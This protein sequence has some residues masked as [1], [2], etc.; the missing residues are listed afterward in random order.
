MAKPAWALAL[1]LAVAAMAVLS[2]SASAQSGCAA[3]TAL[4]NQANAQGLTGDCDTLLSARDT[5]AGTGSLNWS[6]SLAIEEWNGVSV[7]GTSGRVTGLNLRAAGLDGQIPA[8]LGNLDHLQSLHLGEN[9]LNGGIPAELGRLDAL[10]ELYLN[11]NRL[12]GDIPPELD[13][14]GVLQRLYLNGNQLDGAIPPALGGLASLRVLSLSQNRLAGE[15]PVE[16]GLLGSLRELYLNGNQLSGEIPAE[17]G[18]L[19]SLERLYLYGNQFTGVIPTALGGLTNLRV[20]SLSHNQLTGEIPSELYGLTSLQS[21]YLDGNRLD[22]M[23]PDALGRLA[24][25]QQLRLGGNLLTG[26]VPHTLAGFIIDDPLLG[27]PICAA[28]GTSGS[29]TV[30]IA[31]DGPR[32][33]VR[34]NTPIG[35]TATF[36]QPVSNFTAD[37]IRVAFGTVDNFDGTGSSYTFDVTPNAAGAVTVE[38]PAGLATDANDDGNAATGPLPLGIPYDDNNDARISRGEVI[39]A[40]S[41]YFARRINRVQAIWM[42]GLYFTS[43]DPSGRNANAGPD[44]Q[45]LESSPVRLDGTAT[46]GPEGSISSYRWEQV[47]NGSRLVPLAGAD[48]A[49]PTFT[50]PGLSND[51]DF[52]LRLTVTYNNGETSEDEVIITGRP[53][54]GVIVGAVS[55]HTATINSEAVFDIRLRSRPSAEVVIPVSSSDESEGIPQQTDVVFTPENWHRG[56]PVV[57]RGQNPAVQGG[58]QD[59]EIILGDTESEDSYYDGLA[60]S[61]VAMRGIVLEIA[62][63]EEPEPLVANLPATIEPRVS[64]TGRERLSFALSEAPSGMSVDFSYGTISWTP[65]E[66]DEGQTFDVTVKVNDG[67]LFSETTFQVTV[68]QSEPITTEIQGNVLTVDDQ[69]TDL[70]GMSITALPADTSTPSTNPPTLQ[71]LQAALGKASGESV[72]EIPSWITPISDVFVVKSTFENPVQLGF[73]IS[74]L[75][76]DVSPGSIN[77]YAYSEDLDADGASWGQIGIDRSFG[78]TDE[79]PVYVLSLVALQGLAFFGYHDTTPQ[80]AIAPR[81]SNDAVRAPRAAEE[82]L[83]NRPRTTVSEEQSCDPE[84]VDPTEPGFIDTTIK[85]CG[86]SSDDVECLPTHSSW[87]CTYAPDDEVLIKVVNFGEDPFTDNPENI[88]WLGSGL[89]VKDLAISAITAQLGFEELGLAYDKVITVSISRLNGLGKVKWLE[90]RK[91]I[92]ITDDNDY[93]PDEIQGA[94]VHEYF[95]HVQAH[96][97]NFDFTDR[98]LIN[99][100]R[101]RSTVWLLESTALWYEDELGNTYDSFD[102]Y[103]GHGLNEKIME[104]GLNSRKGDDAANP[105]ARAGFIKLLNQACP[106]FTSHISDMFHANLLDFSGIAKLNSLLDD[107]MCDFGTHLGES[108]KGNLE[109]GIAFYNYATQLKNDMRLLDLNEPEDVVNFLPA[110]FTGFDPSLKNVECTY[111]TTN[112]AHLN[113]DYNWL[114]GQNGVFEL[115]LNDIPTAG[116]YSFKIPSISLDDEGIKQAPG[117]GIVLPRLPEGMIA[118][119][120]IEADREII[121][122]IPDIMG[123]SAIGPDGGPQMMGENTIGDDGNPHTWVWVPARNRISYIHTDATGTTCATNSGNRNCLP[124]ILVTLVNSSVSDD[125]DVEVFFTIRDELDTDL[126]AG[127][128]IS[129]P[130]GG[131][132]VSNRVVTISGSIPEES[133]SATK[134]VVVT[135]N[136]IETETALN[137]DGS[138]AAD[139]VVSFGDNRMEAQGFD[140]QGMPVTDETGINIEG[141]ESTSTGR[142][143]L[144]PSRIV[145]VLRWDT[146]TDIDIHSRDG[147]GGHIYFG[148][149]EVGPGSLDYD[150]VVGFGPEVVSYR[151]TD[152]AVY[153]NGTFKVDVNYFSGRRAG[154]PPTN[155]TLNVILNE[156]EVRDRRLRQFRSIEP[157]TLSDRRFNS[158]L[159]VTCSAGRICGLDDFDGSKLASAGSSTA[160]GRGFGLGRSAGFATSTGSAKSAAEQNGVPP[161]ASAY[162]QCMN[163]MEAAIAKSG[164]VDWTCNPDGTKEW[165]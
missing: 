7:D 51:Q 164:S 36:S 101:A 131:A 158:V 153:V 20:L 132:R 104:R 43:P 16:L 80:S 32:A 152:D 2:T 120:T 135:A 84:E 9:R 161:F 26:C 133:R 109:A 96:N 79:N 108:R 67:A 106:R 97:D 47:I 14:L 94:V 116:A 124:E 70:D 13:S 62:G 41:D 38:I 27:L 95:H 75:P 151:A 154:Y 74:Q 29:L 28:P 10:Q 110:A 93:A 18:G 103:K 49:R 30:V 61:N 55:G 88:R 155:Y 148:R 127:P 12:T 42:I 57:V 138:F 3:G 159:T 157:L 63:P 71:D 76:E 21:L 99:A 40:I 45:A 6:P 112:Q 139:V 126:A 149:R 83:T 65:S 87:A 90:G 128:A 39:E 107:F 140:D 134:T 125:V 114:S 141:I 58:E 11:A 91:V 46:T 92:H 52:V 160:S 130:S 82:S 150:D 17:V 136:G 50:L 143:A 72:P 85:V 60:I 102:T 54:P 8:E 4:M 73:P 22:G 105:Y 123:E 118:E 68:I 78:G 35:L 48:T 121:V 81:S 165:P 69:G 100:L 33:Q 119:L 59:Y 147:G 5:L 145:F 34:F 144:I 31:L 89:T 129:S 53:T 19:S 142:N 24:N 98:L 44:A 163:E 113:C 117:T 1:L 37:D 86:P 56:Q 115:R 137:Q 156:T 77:L 15:I 111:A 162:E 122:S 25:L 66:T 146:G 64:Y 23:I